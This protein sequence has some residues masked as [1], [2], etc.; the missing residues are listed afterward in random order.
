MYLAN[1]S[2]TTPGTL[3]DSYTVD[4]KKYMV[5]QSS[6]KDPET[7]KLVDRLE[8]LVLLFIEGGSYI[9]LADDRWQVY[10]LYSLAPY[11]V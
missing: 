11:L 3:I 7:V 5:F 2:F 10:I 4:S 6:L 1:P 8:F 9:D